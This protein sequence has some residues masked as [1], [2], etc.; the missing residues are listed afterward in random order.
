MMLPTYASLFYS[1]LLL[2]GLRSH[3]EQKYSD[4]LIVAIIA[5]DHD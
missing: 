5:I 2:F 3:E 1:S 4:I